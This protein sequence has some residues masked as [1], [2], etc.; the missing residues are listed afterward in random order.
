MSTEKLIE[1]RSTTHGKFPD[2]AQVTECVMDIFRETLGWQKAPGFVKVA[3]FMIVHKISRALNGQLLFDDHW[4]DVQGYAKL[5]E[6]QCNRIPIV[7]KIPC[8]FCAEL[9]P[10]TTPNGCC[11]ECKRDLIEVSGS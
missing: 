1:T 10:K 8:P 9:I 11:P 6:E 3:V 2:N 5:V 7:T 4:K